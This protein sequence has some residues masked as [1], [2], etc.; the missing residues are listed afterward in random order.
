[1]RRWF[2]ERNRKS[3]RSCNYGILLALF[4]SQFPWDMDSFGLLG[5]DDEDKDEYVPS[6]DDDEADKENDNVV[7]SAF[8]LHP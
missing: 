5:S 2:L 1:M 4:V 7:S 3:D 8:P 6:N